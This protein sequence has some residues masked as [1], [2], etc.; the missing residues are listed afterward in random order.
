MARAEE[1]G[2]GEVAHAGELARAK[3]KARAGE[4]ARARE[5]GAGELAVDDFH[6]SQYRGSMLRIYWEWRTGIGEWRK[7]VIHLQIV[8]LFILA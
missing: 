4:M 7:G 1:F 3:E 2:A 5:F 8:Y 6:C